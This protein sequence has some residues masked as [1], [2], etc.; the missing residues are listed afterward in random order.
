MILERYEDKLWSKNVQRT[1]TKN[2]KG[3]KLLL[4][5][6]ICRTN[7]LITGLKCNCCLGYVNIKVQYRSSNRLDC[8][9]WSEVRTNKIIALC[10]VQNY[11]N[12]MIWWNVRW[13]LPAGLTFSAIIRRNFAFISVGTSKSS[14]IFDRT[15]E[16]NFVTWWFYITG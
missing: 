14:W 15:T 11:K 7:W 13:I 3:I 5:E 2:F 16:V 10:H 9:T 12:H 8:N 1:C 6:L 4:F